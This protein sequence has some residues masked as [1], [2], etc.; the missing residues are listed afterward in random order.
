MPRKGGDF[1]MPCQEKV[2]ILQEGLK[3]GQQ[4]LAISNPSQPEDLWNL[5]ERPSLR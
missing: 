4:L 3:V 2:E 5:N 1:A